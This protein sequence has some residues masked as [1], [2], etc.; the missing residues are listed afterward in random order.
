MLKEFRVCAPVQVLFISLV[1]V[2]ASDA[3]AQDVLPVDKNTTL[4][5]ALTA[6]RPE[7]GVRYR[8]EH[9]NDDVAQKN[10]EASTL[11]TVLG[12]KTGDF[13]GLSVRLLGQNVT[14]VG[15]DDFNDGTG[16]PG[17]KTQ[18]AV[19]A[20]PSATDLLE[21]YLGFSGFRDTTLKIGRQIIT[22]RNAP[23]HRF[24]GT[25]LW[26]QNWQ[27]HDGFSLVNTTLPDLT[28]S[29][30]YSWN[31]N[32]IFSEKAVGAR[33][34]FDSDSHFVN[35]QYGGNRLGSLEAYAYLLD[36]DNAPAD[37]TATYGLRFSGNH[38]LSTRF[39]VIYA[40][41][42]PRQTDYGV[43]QADVGENYLL[44][45]IGSG[46]RPG[47]IFDSVTFRLNYELLA[48]NGISSFRTPLATGH[49][50]QGW[51]D[52]FLA[53]PRDGIED[54]YLTAG[55]N[56]AGFDFSA[57]YHSLSSDNDSYDYGTEIDLQ[58]VR[59]L[60]KHFNFGLKY[61]DYDAD[62]NITNI[63]RN[64]NIARDVSKFWAWLEFRYQ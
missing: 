33:A 30:A 54:I 55:V 62:K 53:T 31:V 27:N 21:G 59:R 22:Y 41:E 15:P 49:A 56:L 47:N 45:E 46:L 52:R 2:S 17:A 61:S 43:N 38:P 5:T 34:N 37:S 20:D 29:Y 51:A 60:G 9:V 7:L 36:F 4:F 18:Y 40:V 11:R 32:R 1:L 6:G 35:L 23:L 39:R 42:Y 10:A 16:R 12:Y 63:N 58:L 19:V 50:F 48:G 24:M 14:D 3:Y 25:V 57:V 44:L 13:H 64:G 26:R 8:Y 28:I